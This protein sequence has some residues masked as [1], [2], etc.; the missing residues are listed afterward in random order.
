[1]T[2]VRASSDGCARAVTHGGLSGLDYY[3][4]LAAQHAPGLQLLCGNVRDE[5]T[6]ALAVAPH[7]VFERGGVRVGVAA[8]LGKEAWDVTGA[9]SRAGLRWEDSVVAARASAA[10]LRAARCDVLVCLSHTGVDRGDR[11]RCLPPPRPSCSR[12]FA[13]HQP[14]ATAGTRTARAVRR[15]LQRAR[16]AGMALEPWTRG[17]APGLPLTRVAHRRR[18]SALL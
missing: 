8:L 9:A 4:A 10:A 13:R 16:C 1:M 11:V 12:C 7:A 5:A 3:K 17:P 15:D 18:C 6:G 14:A 2:S